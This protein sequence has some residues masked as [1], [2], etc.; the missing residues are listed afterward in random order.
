MARVVLDHAVIAFVDAR[1]KTVGWN[2][3]SIGIGQHGLVFNWASI[4]NDRG[5]WMKPWFVCFL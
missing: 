2:V 4:G 3:N 1:M 5:M